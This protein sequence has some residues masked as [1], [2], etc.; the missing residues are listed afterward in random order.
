MEKCANTMPRGN[1]C[2]MFSNAFEDGFGIDE[3]ALSMM[4]FPSETVKLLLI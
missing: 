2:L 4:K 3:C 1:R